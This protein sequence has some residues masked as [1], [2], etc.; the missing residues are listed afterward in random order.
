[1]PDGEPQIHGGGA[2]T[3]SLTDHDLIDEC[4]LLVYP[5]VLGRGQRLFPAGGLPTSF[6]LTGSLTS[7]GRIAVHTY[8]PTE[9]PAFGPFAPEQ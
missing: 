4:H 5:V 9:R 7:S 8:R 2:L 6:E 3:R 1:M